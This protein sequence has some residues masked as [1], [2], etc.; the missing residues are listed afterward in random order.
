MVPF[1][2]ELGA[3]IDPTSGPAAE[4]PYVR[5][6]QSPQ[7]ARRFFRFVR[8]AVALD[9]LEGVS[10]SVDRDSHCRSSREDASRSHLDDRGLSRAGSRGLYPSDRLHSGETLLAPHHL[11]YLAALRS[12]LGP[13]RSHLLRGVVRTAPALG[14]DRWRFSRH[15]VLSGGLRL[16]AH[17]KSNVGNA[18]RHLTRHCSRHVM[19]FRDLK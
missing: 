7:A 2:I 8:D 10:G 5:C 12:L 19:H 11:A 6:R 15:S 18:G 13:L 4:R 1:G 14:P 16:L 17:L 9:S 3:S